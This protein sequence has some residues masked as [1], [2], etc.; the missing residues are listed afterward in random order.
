[1]TSAPGPMPS[2]IIATSRASVPEE[3]AMAWSVSSR[4]AS[5]ASSASFSGAENEPLAVA[6]AGDGREDLVANR[7]VLGLEVEQRNAHLGRLA[8]G[9]AA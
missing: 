6:D 7:A 1:M 3:T 9:H 5:S 2:A 4:A 8:D